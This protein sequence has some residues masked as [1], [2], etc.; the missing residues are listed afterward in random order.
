MNLDLLTAMASLSTIT[1]M[2]L[3]GII[4]YKDVKIKKYDDR[5]IIRQYLKDVSD[6]H[7]EVSKTFNEYIEDNSRKNLMFFSQSIESYLNEFE[8]FA[9]FIIHSRL[10]K[11][12]ALSERDL[13]EALQDHIFFIVSLVGKLHEER[14]KREDFDS[15]NLI[16]RK[17]LSQSF[18]LIFTQYS[19]EIYKDLRDACFK[20]HLF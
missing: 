20:A 14:M 19:Y 11:H 10:E 1:A 2:V 8:E 17:N 6:K 12:K 3:T 5:R 13:T 4:F 9:S 7:I 18:Q 15:K 16:K